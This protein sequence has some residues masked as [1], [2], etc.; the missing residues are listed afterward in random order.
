MDVITI[1]K[2]SQCKTAKEINQFYKHKYSKD[3]YKSYCKTCA[4]KAKKKYLSENR[5]KSLS[6]GAEWRKNN[7]EKKRQINKAYSQTKK[8]REIIY[9]SALK[10]RSRKHKVVFKIHERKRLLERDNWTC[11]NC[12]CQVHDRSDKNWN[13]PD[14]AH[15]DHIIPISK[16]GSSEPSNLRVLCR[17]CNLGKQNKVNKQL[18]FLF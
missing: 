1:K 13:T 14:K 4:S 9:L 11:Q 17:T 8:G 5:E 18:E 7:K 6:Y 10:R 3:G 12:G 2:C 15:I 16:G